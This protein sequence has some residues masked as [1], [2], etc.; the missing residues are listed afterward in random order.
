MLNLNVE[1]GLLISLLVNASLSF[2]NL[3]IAANSA[4]MPLHCAYKV[5]L[6]VINASWYST[7][8]FA[9]FMCL[10]HTCTLVCEWEKPTHVV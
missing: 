6:T 7:V 3:L 2:K 5:N 4:A 1:R 10:T 9:G 8:A